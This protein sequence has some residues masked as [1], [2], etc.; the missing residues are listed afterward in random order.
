MCHPLQDS[1]L[2]LSAATTEV[3]AECG[4]AD[5]DYLYEAAVQAARGTFIPLVVPWWSVWVFGPLIV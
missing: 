1:L 2:C 4:K 3:A 5:N